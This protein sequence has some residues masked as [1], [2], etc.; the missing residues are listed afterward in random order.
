MKPEV[1][2][3]SVLSFVVSEQAVS[4]SLLRASSILVSKQAVSLSL[5]RARAKRK[6]KIIKEVTC[7][8]KQFLRGVKNCPAF[9]LELSVYLDLS[10]CSPK[11]I[12]KYKANNNPKK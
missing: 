9:C 8:R 5:L 7:K 2:R 11:Q 12:I 1:S 3:F 4:L 6:D 10:Y